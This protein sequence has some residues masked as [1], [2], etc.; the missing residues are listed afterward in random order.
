MCSSAVNY[1]TTFLG[2]C[3]RVVVVVVVVVVVEKEI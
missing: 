3:V 1:Q 2:V